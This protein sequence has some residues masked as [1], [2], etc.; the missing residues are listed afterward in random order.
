M[1]EEPEEHI[2]LLDKTNTLGGLI[3]NYSGLIGVSDDLCILIFTI[4]GQRI[5]GRDTPEDL[6]MKHN[7][8]I[9][10]STKY[11]SAHAHHPPS[12]DNDIMY[13]IKQLWQAYFWTHT[14]NSRTTN[15]KLKL[16]TKIFCN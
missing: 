16:K 1:S 15:W 6:R 5:H 7:D 8:I 11:G 3:K 12:S 9:S 4:K 14:K 2:R 13:C 10:M